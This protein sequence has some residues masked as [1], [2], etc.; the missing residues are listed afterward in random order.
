MATPRTGSTGSHCWVSRDRRGFSQTSGVGLQCAIAP[1]AKLIHPPQVPKRSVQGWKQN[2]GAVT[3]PPARKQPRAGEIRIV[4]V[5]N[6]AF[7][8]S[9]RGVG[10]NQLIN[11]FI[12]TKD[13]VRDSGSV[14]FPAEAALV[15]RVARSTKRERGLFRSCT[16]QERRR[17][18][19]G[20]H[21]RW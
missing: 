9:G 16:A 3:A 15:P 10:N 18:M 21:L 19:E 11:G 2:I 6:G 14:A 17:K 13:K 4:L 7:R 8:D 1:L 12:R 5:H 20:V